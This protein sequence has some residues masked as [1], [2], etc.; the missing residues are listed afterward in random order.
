MH[1]YNGVLTILVLAC[2]LYLVFCV[3]VNVKITVSLFCVCVHSAWKGHPQNDLYGV[4]WDVKP[5]SLTHL[6]H[7]DLD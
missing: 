2:F 5:Y 3:S 6:L 7:I 4:G 1:A